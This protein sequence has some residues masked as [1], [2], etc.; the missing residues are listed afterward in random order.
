MPRRQAKSASARLVKPGKVTATDN[1]SVP[2]APA[3]PPAPPS[4]AVSPAPPSP[5]TPLDHTA[6]P[7]ILAA[8][9]TFCDDETLAKFARL[10]SS[11]HERSESL[12]YSHVLFAANTV[13]SRSGKTISPSPLANP[14]QIVAHQHQPSRRAVH[15]ARVVDFQ[16]SFFS[17]GHKGGGGHATAAQVLRVM[18]LDIPQ[19]LAQIPPSYRYGYGPKPRLQPMSNPMGPYI[20]TPSDVVVEK[21][22]IFADY[23]Q[24]LPTVWCEN[25]DARHVVVTIV[26]DPYIE[27]MPIGQFQPAPEQATDITFLFLARPTSTSIGRAYYERASMDA[28][29]VYFDISKADDKAL[30]PWCMGV[31]HDF[32][33]WFDLP[34][35]EGRPRP[36]YTFVG[37]ENVPP[38]LI[39][40]TGS[41]DL[42]GETHAAL[43]DLLEKGMYKKPG[44]PAKREQVRED[45]S[46][47]SLEEYRA[48]HTQ[49][50]WED[51]TVQYMRPENTPIISVE[52]VEL[53]ETWRLVVSHPTATLDEMRNCA[54]EFYKSLT[55]WP[56]LYRR[57]EHH[58]DLKDLEYM[59]EYAWRFM[60]RLVCDE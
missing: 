43:L 5:A 31:L 23:T 39:G 13:V 51:A 11:V 58:L 50:E 7:H 54:Q 6:F 10:G 18:W 42:G 60:G 27:S 47:M 2:P 53:L 33:E 22:V 12:L 3:V 24:P 20:R 44:V 49:S 26:Y 41:L 48:T 55:V 9:L 28:A 35:N 52:S 16:G 1:P 4:P 17:Y 40:A 34:K 32:V 37:L 14:D 36:K 59:Q 15:R 46:F 30:W 45:V 21:M 29:E 19:G 56:Y 38:S 8:V 25:P 57:P